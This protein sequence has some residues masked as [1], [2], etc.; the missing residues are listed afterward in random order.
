MAGL[1]KLGSTVGH[2]F[3]IESVGKNGQLTTIEGNTN[4]QLSREGN[5]VYRLTRRTINS[6]NLGFIDYIDDNVV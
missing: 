3:L 6:V 1:L 2:I 4:Q 5:G